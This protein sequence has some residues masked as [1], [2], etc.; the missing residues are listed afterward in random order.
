[1]L[2]ITTPIPYTN[3]KPH[4]GHLLEAVFTDTLARFYRTQEQKVKL[5][6][7]LDQHG[8]KIFEKAQEN[9][10]Q[11]QEFVDQQSQNFKKLWQ[12]F[13]INWDTFIETSSKS[14][15]LTAQLVWKK[16]QQQGL[17]YKKTYQGLYCVGCEDFYAPSQL[18]NGLCPIH[19]TKPVKTKEENYFFKLSQFKP[20]IQKYLKTAWIRPRHTTSEF[21]N[22]TEELQDIS[23]SR[24]KTRLPWGIAIPSDQGQVMY[25]WFEALIN[26]LTACT[27]P[28]DTQSLDNQ[29]ISLGEWENRAWKNIQDSYPIDIMY[30]SKEVAKFHLVVWIGMLEGLG[31]PLPQK[32]LTHGLIN[33]K[34][35]V[36]FSKSL[37]NGVFPE[38]LVSKVGYEGARFILLYQINIDGDTNFDWNSAIDCYNSH[39]ANNIGNL[40]I[41][42]TNLIQRFL[43]GNL[44]YDQESL[45]RSKDT[46]QTF[47]QTISKDQVKALDV[48]KKL[49]FDFKGIQ[50][51]M[52]A[53]NTKMALTKIIEASTLANQL[54][55]V[56]QPWT[57]FKNSKPSKSKEGEAVLIFLVYLLKNIG[58]NLKIFLPEAGQK[59]L[60][61]VDK[62]K[63]LK[64]KPLFQKV[65]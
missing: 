41:R 11:A 3:S 4:L 56:T 10:Q 28:A 36:K 48:H 61:A 23:I 1:M 54:L 24:E 63:I 14:H 9:G 51:D 6:M 8:L 30:L 22:F 59:I 65:E 44:K 42:T 49:D 45:Q 53:L 39:L 17:I 31:L 18:E 47:L 34:N 7:G 20:Q 13:G 58:L 46:V 43:D 21:L 35:G 55:E 19:K 38:D 5:T 32:A 57:L 16:L 12:Q 40:L 27:D 26:Y 25:V 29:K 2:V 52:Q 15:K 60:T 64:A 62:P 50:K 37:N 33:D